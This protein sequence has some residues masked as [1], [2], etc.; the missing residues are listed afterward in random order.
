[1]A[2]GTWEITVYPPGQA[3]YKLHITAA[4]SYQAKQ[5]AERQNPGARCVI[6]MKVG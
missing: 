5:I 3:Q 4:S 6:G 1:M 2:Q